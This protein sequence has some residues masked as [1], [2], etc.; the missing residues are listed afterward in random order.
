[1]QLENHNGGNVMKPSGESHVC[2]NFEDRR[3]KW[4]KTSFLAGMKQNKGS[5][6]AL[7]TF[8]SHVSAK[9]LVLKLN[10][11]IALTNRIAGF[12]IVS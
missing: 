2:L 5:R 6:G 12:Y 8:V 3:P 9:S 4:P 11:K 7:T 10:P 1:M